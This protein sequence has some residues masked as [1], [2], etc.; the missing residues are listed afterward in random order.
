MTTP[1]KSNQIFTSTFKSK[2]AFAFYL[3][4]RT[5]DLLKSRVMTLKTAN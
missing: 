2:T 3:G 1:F 4:A 5:F